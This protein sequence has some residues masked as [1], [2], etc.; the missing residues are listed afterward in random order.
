MGRD[1]NILD[2][3]AR[4]SAAAERSYFKALRQHQASRVRNHKAEAGALHA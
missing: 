4:Y 1:G 2:K 3:L